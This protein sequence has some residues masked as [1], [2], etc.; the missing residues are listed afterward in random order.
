MLHHYNEKDIF[1]KLQKNYVH[2]YNVH[3]YN[4]CL[5]SKFNRYVGKNYY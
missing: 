2:N 1:K 5:A 4:I 3:N